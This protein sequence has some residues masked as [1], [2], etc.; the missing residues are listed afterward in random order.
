MQ[1]EEVHYLAARSRCTSLLQQSPY[2]LRLYL[3]RARCHELLG[4]PD[5]AA[6]DAYKA[7]LLTD[8]AE[9]GEYHEA[10]CEAL[11]L[12]CPPVLHQ[13]QVLLAQGLKVLQGQ[14]AEGAEALAVEAYLILTRMLL[15][16]GDRTN[17]KDFVER[18][19][20]MSPTEDR[21]QDLR[22]RITTDNAASTPT[23]EEL[24]AKTRVGRSQVRTLVRRELY[25][26]NTHEPDRFSEETLTFL[27]S[28]LKKNAPKCEIMAVDLPLLTRFD[29]ST[30][31]KRG[32]VVKQ[33][34]MFARERIAPLERVLL[35]PSTLSANTRLFEPL[36]DACSTALPEIA[37]DSEC[38]SCLSCNEVCFCSKTCHERAQETYHPAVCGFQDHDIVAKDPSPDSAADKLYLLLVARTIA[39]AQTQDK[40]PL[41]LNDTKFLWGDFTSSSAPATR[42]LPFD[43]QTNIAQP[44]HILEH[45]GLDPY[46]PLML[47]RYDIWVLNTMFAKFRGV[48]SAKLNPRTL[49][50]DVAAVHPL[51]SLANHSC[52]PNVKWQWG[53]EENNCENREK[54]A[55]GLSARGEADMVQW[56]TERRFGGIM[57]GEEILNHYCDIEMDFKQRREW[58]IGALGGICM[59]ERCKWESSQTDSTNGDETPYIDSEEM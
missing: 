8:E 26:W 53:A 38:A 36:C 52:A 32:S 22:R 24:P 20:R 48:A 18:G 2:D 42:T 55:M 14:I 30:D 47:E 39:M 41:D 16:C 23:P 4:Y 58:A 59:C 45:M 3:Q 43:F 56:G 54:G 19:C 27:N 5:L 49:C 10:V 7:L 12:N 31:H 1:L 6:G 50:P 17:A 46:T 11:S 29:H 13:D 9:G 57:K 51:W 44:I 37:S 40:H 25:P 33:L 15:Q 21:L 34:G 28:Q 35:E